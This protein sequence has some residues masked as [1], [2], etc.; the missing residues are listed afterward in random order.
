MRE[1]TVTTCFHVVTVHSG[2][3]YAPCFMSKMPSPSP[4]GKAPSGKAPSG[5]APSGKAPSGKAQVGK[6]QA[7]TR[8][9]IIAWSFWDWGSAAFNT[10][11]VTFVFSRYLVGGSHAASDPVS[12][13][14]SSG[15]ALGLTDSQASVRL[16]IAV[17][18]AGVLIAVLAP[19][20]GQRA[21]AFGRRRR[22]VGIWT[23]AIVVCSFGLFFVKPEPDYLVLGLA[24]YAAGLLFFEFAEVSYNAMLRQIST[25]KTIGRVSGFGWSMGYFGGI[26][27]LLIAYVAFISGDDD[28]PTAGLFGVTT[29]GALNIRLVAIF[30]AVWFAIFAI[31]VLLK[32]PEI[33]RDPLASKLSFAA[34]YRLLFADIKRLFRTDRNTLFFLGASALFRDGMA[35]IFTIAAILAIS[36]YDVPDGDILIF[37]IAANVVSA[38]GALA[39][40]RYDDSL[41][42]KKVIVISLIGILVS[43][44][45]LLVLSGQTAFWVMGLI[46]CLFVGPAQSASRTYMARL[47][48]VGEEGKMF[49]L[50]ATTGRAVAFIAP[51][52]YAVL[53]SI[54]DNERAGGFGVLAVI[55]A[56][57]IALKFVRSPEPDVVDESDGAVKAV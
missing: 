19:I 17:T 32:I 54:T 38:I 28:A 1:C 6:A 20:A 3:G 2:A 53:T 50:Y 44:S 41:G 14:P 12:E 8:G 34:S 22:S 13:W 48:K 35:Y 9:Q 29:D 42:P 36:I 40:G 5:K 11:V 7:G 26:V 10:V 31:P 15:V 52:L 51:A 55:A 25:P 33:E 27:L 46:L 18:I 43:G 4:S 39:A 47:T 56:G 21:D 49:G 30:A 24:L 23:A 45:I 37:G 57:L 16:S